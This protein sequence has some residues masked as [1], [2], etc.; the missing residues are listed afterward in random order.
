MSQLA[1]QN[2]GLQFP[3]TKKLRE[4]YAGLRIYLDAYLGGRVEAIV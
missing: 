4:W 1:Q 2:R 3:D